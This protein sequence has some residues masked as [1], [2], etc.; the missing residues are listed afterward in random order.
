MT[1]KIFRA[2]APADAGLASTRTAPVGIPAGLRYSGGIYV[3][4]YPTERDYRMAPLRREW[5]ENGQLPGLLC[6]LEAAL[7]A[8]THRKWPYMS[9]RKVPYT[10]RFIC[11]A[12]PDVCPFC[13]LPAY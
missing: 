11:S 8:Q 7:A 6:A 12:H 5:R 3:A 2:H 9:A 13:G 1:A 10:G 4:V